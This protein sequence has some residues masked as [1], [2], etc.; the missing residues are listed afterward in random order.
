[1]ARGPLKK[2][3]KKGKKGQLPLKGIQGIEVRPTEQQIKAAKGVVEGKPIKEAFTEAGY[4]EKT[5][6]SNSAELQKEPG[7]L[8]ALD[9]AFK[10]AG[11][12]IDNIAQVIKDGYSATRPVVLKSR[13]KDYPDYSERRQIA[14]FHAELIDLFPNAEVELNNTGSLSVVIKRAAK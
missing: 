2:K 5:V 7:Y 6:R 1:M 14:R 4:S 13:I 12:G 3:I 10:R 8:K 9:E 11:V